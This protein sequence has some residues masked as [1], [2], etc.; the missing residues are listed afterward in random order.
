MR[1]CSALT[2]CWLLNMKDPMHHAMLAAVLPGRFFATTGTAHHCGSLQTTKPRKKTFRCALV[3]Q[4][5][6]LNFRSAGLFHVVCSVE[7]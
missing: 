3:G 7:T 1:G 6:R 2:A 5:G 4:G